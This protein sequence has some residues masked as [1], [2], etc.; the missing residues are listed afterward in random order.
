M[1]ICLLVRY[2][3]KFLCWKSVCIS[4][5][6]SLGTLSCVDPPLGTPFVTTLETPLSAADIARGTLELSWL[7]RLW[8]RFVCRIQQDPAIQLKRRREER[9]VLENELPFNIL[10]KSHDT[11]GYGFL[12]CIGPATKAQVYCPDFNMD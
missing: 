9:K 3:G 12:A 8:L 1:G 4:S 2:P 6:S 5:T 7:R 10:H 11:G